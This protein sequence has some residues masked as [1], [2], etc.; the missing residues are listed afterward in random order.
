L[1]PTARDLSEP[2]RSI[3]TT[4]ELIS[5]YNSGLWIWDERHNGQVGHCQ[6]YVQ[7]LPQDRIIEVVHLGLT[8]LMGLARHALGP[9]WRPNRIELASDPVDLTAH[10]SGLE[11]LPISFNRPRTSVWVDEKVLTAPLPRYDAWDSPPADETGRAS[12][13]E[14]AQP[15]ILLRS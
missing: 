9:D 11:D 2:M 13:L 1:N 5:S 4:I 14:S 8:N 12:F 10:F 7:N 6:K 3:Q 15:P